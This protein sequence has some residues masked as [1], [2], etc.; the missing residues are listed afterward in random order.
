MAGGHTMTQKILPA[1]LNPLRQA[2]IRFDQFAVT[3]F[4]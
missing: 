4:G 2:G 1:E 3:A